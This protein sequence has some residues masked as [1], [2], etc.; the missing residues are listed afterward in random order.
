M[1]YTTF[2]ATA[3][4]AFP[5]LTPEMEERF[6]ALDGLYREWNARINVISRKDMDG[7]YDHHVLHS[8]AI[9]R[10]LQ[11]QQRLLPEGSEVLDLGTGGGFPGI[12]LAILFPGAQ[13]TLCDSVGKKIIVADAVAKSLGLSNVTT[14]NARVESLGKTFDYVVSRAVAT[15]EDLYPW[16][17]DRYRESILLLKGGDGLAEELARAQ[18][19]HRLSKNA[20]ATWPVSA[21]LPGEWFE[22]KFVVEVK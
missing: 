21:W 14:V 5:W 6:A 13:F 20:V 11:L 19:R 12:P 10:Y 8:L 15:L 16:V 3:R 1:D 18:A 22:G 7:L 17:K 4:R 9:A 2:I